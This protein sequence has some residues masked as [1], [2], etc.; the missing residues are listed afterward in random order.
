M[1][2][3]ARHEVLT[4]SP[5]K[6][7]IRDKNTERINCTCNLLPQKCIF[8]KQYTIGSALRIVLYGAI[9]YAFFSKRAPMTVTWSNFVNNMLAY[10]RNQG[11]VYKIE[12]GNRHWGAFA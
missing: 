2:N 9:I 1:Y 5:N 12:Q 11:I 4:V 8:L 7:S 3:K 6:R 10:R